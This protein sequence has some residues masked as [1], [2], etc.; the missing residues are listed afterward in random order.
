MLL[1][2]QLERKVEGEREGRV[3]E[4]CQQLREGSRFY[5][6]SVAGKRER[7]GF[8]LFKKGDDEIA[9]RIRQAQALSP[10]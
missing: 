3:F 5:R 6:G 9:R 1:H 2:R 8:I 4:L 7:E 10:F